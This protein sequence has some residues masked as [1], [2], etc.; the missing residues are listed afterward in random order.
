M[1]I[2]AFAESMS[3]G[4]VY[5]LLTILINPEVIY[6]S[7]AGNFFMSLLKISDPSAAIFPITAFFIFMVLVSGCIRLILIWANIRYSFSVG[8]YLNIKAYQKT[9]YQ[10]YEVHINRNSNIVINGILHKVNSIPYNVIMP[11]LGILSSAFLLVVVFLAL[12]LIEPIITFIIF[13]IF[14]SIYFLMGL[15]MRRK[16]KYNSF[17]IAFE[18]SRVLQ[19]LN[20]G[21]GGIRDVL[22]DGSQRLY[23]SLYATADSSLRKSQASNSFISSSPRI[24]VETIAISLIAGAAYFYTKSEGNVI[25]AISVLGALALGAQRM[26]PNLQQIYASWASLKG[27][28]QTLV[29][30]LDL[31]NQKQQYSELAPDKKRL[32]FLEAISLSDICFSYHQNGKPILTRINLLIKRGDRVGFVGKTGCG[33]STLMDIVMGL[34]TPTS[35]NMSVDGTVVG[36]NNQQAWRANVAHV[37]QSIFLL[38]GSIAENVAFGIPASEIDLYRVKEACK[39]AQLADSIESWPDKYLTNVGERGVRLSGGQRQRIGIARALY[40]YAN[41]IFFDEATSALDSQTEK[42]VMRAIE[43]LG[44]EYTVIIVAHRISTLKFCDQIISLNDGK[45]KSIYSYE[46]LLRS[47][48][49]R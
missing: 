11:L 10:P 45:I 23:S 38:D 41:V 33:K 4:A 40:K 14:G 28:E 13:F 37:P 29:D 7:N 24:F 21:F 1:V 34:L 26:L 43:E 30:G 15:I 18:S 17:K 20:E 36:H 49:N 46:D 32:R 39:K 5:P 25:G 48:K 2:A 3:I 9:L 31:L 8:A 6:S 44:R 16:L 27:G 19:L 12:L 22:I 47:E 42:D 35:G